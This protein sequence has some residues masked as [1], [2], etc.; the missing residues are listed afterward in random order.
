MKSV[1]CRHS[2]FELYFF[3]IFDV[4]FCV[5]LPFLVNSA[6]PFPVVAHLSTSQHSTAAQHHPC[7]AKCK[8]QKV[9]TVP[10]FRN[11][12][13]FELLLLFAAVK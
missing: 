7:L 10:V 3:K 4:L 11:T 5:L 8:N 2:V 6:V 1:Q 9:L 12:M 13:K